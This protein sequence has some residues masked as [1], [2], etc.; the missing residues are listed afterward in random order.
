M[1]PKD[2]L[3]KAMIRQTIDALNSVSAS[4]ERLKA[5]MRI[6]TAQLP[7]YP[8]SWPCAVW[9]IPLDRSSWRRLAM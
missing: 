8:I 6:L 1:L 7:E 9:R 2:A 5:E 3:T 4:L